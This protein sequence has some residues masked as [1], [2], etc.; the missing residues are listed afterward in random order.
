MI[1]FEN[2]PTHPLTEQIVDDLLIRTD[3]TSRDFF[4]VLT[5][6][7]FSKVAASMRVMISTP[8]QA[9]DIPVN[10]FAISL[11]PSGF[12]KNKAVGALERG[13]ISGFRHRFAEEVFPTI[14]DQR[15]WQLAIQ[16]AAVNGK[17]EDDEKA[18]YDKLFKEAGPYVF[19]SKSATASSI[20]QLRGKLL[21]SAVGAINIQ[22]DEI[23]SNIT[24]RGV[25]E[26]LNVFLELYDMGHT[27]IAMTKNTNE[28]ARMDDIPGLTPA[29]LL[30]FGEPTKLFDGSANET[31]FMQLLGTGYARRSLF[32]WGE[33]QMLETPP[34]PED[35]YQKRIQARNTASNNALKNHFAM[36][37]DPARHGWLVTVPEDVALRKTVY[38]LFC[39]DRVREISFHED[40]RRTEMEH[41]HWKALKLA[42]AL[43][44]V[45]E[46]T[47][48]TMDHLLAAIGI[49]E[50]SGEALHRMLSREKPH[51]KLAKYIA[52]S[53][54]ELTQADL[55]EAFP[56]CR[57][58]ANA[59][60]EM[61]LAQAW[62]YKN[63]V[64][65]RKRFEDGIELFSGE[66][67]QSTD[68]NKMILSY[69]EHPAYNYETEEFIPF[70]Q[71][72]NLMQL[73]D[74]NWCNHRFDNNHRS[75]QTTQPGFNMVVFDFDQGASLDLVHELLAGYRF[76]TYT[77]KRHTPAH[78]RF[79]LILP[80]NYELKLDKEDYAIFVDNLGGWLPVLANM[81]DDASRQRSKKWLTHPGSYHYGEGDLVDC[82]PFIPRTKRNE[83]FRSEMKSLESLDNLERWFAQRIA[84]GNRNNQMI[85]FALALVDSGMSFT[86]VEQAVLDFN[87]KINNSLSEDEIRNTILVTVARKIHAA[88]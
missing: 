80:I 51:V 55:H 62:G 49:V 48:I 59:K 33:K 60:R 9:E 47:E 18:R 21:M 11:A 12:G 34:T 71:L 3:A 35:I 1:D 27:E 28:N 37:A 73:P 7:Y 87:S 39:K 6:Y 64:I 82:L 38:E 61:T 41:R 88:A 72:H 26:A 68:L 56:F 36:L 79:R 69:S 53:D 76:M 23:G 58:E 57:S 5:G 77:T 31:A 19:T 52:E 8:D 43:A 16:K 25:T 24:D 44:F 14:S 78:H 40:I 85:K 17:P 84:S 65:I 30:V 46:S 70:D 74:W 4:R 2:L 42:G 50:Q 83:E 86:A 54:V 66:T 20:Q 75:D 13:I 45:D 63:H 67:L 10:C 15:L 22:V 81:T 32:A 29:N